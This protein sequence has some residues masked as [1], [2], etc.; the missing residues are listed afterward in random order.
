[1]PAAAAPTLNLAYSVKGGRRLAPVRVYD[2]GKSTFFQFAEA[3]E[4]AA[5]FVIGPDGK[6]E[7]VNAQWRGPYMVVDQIAREF[8]L[9][10]GRASMR[11]RNDGWREPSAPA[12]PR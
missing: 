10:V 7:M 9:R 4:A 6:E 12:A 1:V 8:V 5:I 3:A 2:D 11:I